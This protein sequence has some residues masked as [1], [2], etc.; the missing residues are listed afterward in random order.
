MTSAVR[1]DV[2]F[3]GFLL[4]R[5][6]PSKLVPHFL[7]VGKYGGDR[8]PGYDRDTERKYMA[9]RLCSVSHFFLF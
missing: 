5:V 7:C 6:E 9:R 8:V 1:K 4:G 2:L 3:L